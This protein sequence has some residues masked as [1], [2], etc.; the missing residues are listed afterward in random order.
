MAVRRDDATGQVVIE[1]MECGRVVAA[2]GV[3]HADVLDVA[4]GMLRYSQWGGGSC[5][6][7]CY[8]TL[9]LKS[10]SNVKVV[11]YCV[12]RC[13]LRV[14]FKATQYEYFGVPISMVQTLYQVGS[15]GSFL[16]REVFSKPDEFP[17]FQIEKVEAKSD[18]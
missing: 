7:A 1:Q 8:Y 18:G 2:F 11:E 4:D 3:A 10:S 12:S 6:D 9:A 17:C 15:V 16:N 14:R 5:D 13:R